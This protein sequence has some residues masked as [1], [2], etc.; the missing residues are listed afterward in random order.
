VVQRHRLAVPAL[1]GQSI[2]R[3]QL[4]VWYGADSVEATVRE[5]AYHWYHGLLL[6]AEGFAGETVAIE[7]KV[8]DVACDALLLDLRPCVVEF[9]ALL[10][11]A[12]YTWTRQVG[13]RLRHEGH[14]GLL[15]PSVRYPAGPQLRR[16]QPRGIV[17]AARQLPA[18]VSPQGRAR[19]RR[20]ASRQ[21][22][23]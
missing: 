2:L 16:L 20:E 19:P 5:T 21:D 9:P 23:A 18:H 22:L 17:Q 14:P 7:R 3:R 12:D 10:H 11:K 1:A 15:A 13:A 6:D 4:R 8:Y